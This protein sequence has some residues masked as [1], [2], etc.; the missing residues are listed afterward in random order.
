MI[1]FAI[2]I[3]G[4]VGTGYAATSKSTTFVPVP[5]RIEAQFSEQFADARDVRWEEG[6]NF[7]KVTFEAWGRTLFAF[8]AFD[9]DL[10]GVATNLS[11]PTLPEKLQSQIKH[12]YAGYWITDLFAYHNMDEHGFVVTLENADKVVVLKAKADGGWSLYK[13]SVKQ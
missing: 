8:Y 2:A 4:L 6:K 11:S 3:L 5:V 9:G 10:M 12:S 1:A 7:F 13:T